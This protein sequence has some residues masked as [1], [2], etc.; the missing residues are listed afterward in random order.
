MN[1]LLDF[2]AAVHAPFLHARGYAGT[3]AL[4]RVLQPVP[5][6]R[7]LELGFGTGQT[8]VEL[9]SHFPGLELH[10]AEKSPR[11]L[12]TARR[13]FRFCG[14][15]PNLLQRYETTLPYPDGY[16]DA[17]FCESVLAIVP[18]AEL[19]GLVAEIYRILKPGGRLCANESLWRQG[20]PPATIAEINKTC[21]A[22]FGLVQASGDY[23]YPAD[24]QRLC[25]TAGFTL[26]TLQSLEVISDHPGPLLPGR[27]WRAA[28]FSRWG[29]MKKKLWPPFRQ[30]E[31]RLREQ[32]QQF[33]AYGLYLLGWLLV[34]DKKE[35]TT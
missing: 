7:I 13:R 6:E 32:E 16:F 9:L 27:R 17:V 12:A 31:R 22:A 4:L 8:Q 25:E 23:P 34:F 19:P 26:H 10:G 35:G 2:F 24:W 18:D 3:L 28:L 14:L 20:T 30:Q 21:L 5:G 33:A 11:M 15:R 1:K 29:W